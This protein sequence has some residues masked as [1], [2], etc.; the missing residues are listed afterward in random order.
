M[1]SFLHNCI[2]MLDFT[3]INFNKFIYLSFVTIYN[4]IYNQLKDI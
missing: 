4:L 2:S 1:T 3:L